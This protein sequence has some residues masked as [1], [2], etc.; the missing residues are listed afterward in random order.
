[1]VSTELGL[2]WQVS[3]LPYAAL[4]DGDGLLRARGMVNTR[5]H[6]ESLFEA[7]RLGVASVQEYLE[8][9][10]AALEPAGDELEEPAGGQAL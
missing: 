5:E 2:A 8:L 6:L 10:S 4:V 9:E 1:V 3:K 7:R